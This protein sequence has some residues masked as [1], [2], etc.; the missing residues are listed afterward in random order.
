MTG[1]EK[2]LYLRVTVKLML[3]IMGL[4]L[5]YTLLISVQSPEE[6]H[7]ETL[8]IPL[9]QLRPGDLERRQWGNKRLLILRRPEDASAQ[10]QVLRD[11]LQDPDSRYSEQP[12]FADNPYRSRD[13]RYFIALDYGSDLNCQLDYVG[14]KRSGPLEKPWQGGFKDRCRGSWYDDAGRVYKDQTALRNLTVPAY[15]IEGQILILGED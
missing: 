10:R 12:E 11:A 2:R 6:K 4:G 8:S 3:L 7:R 5:L 9:T 14:P 13:P 15:R 1:E